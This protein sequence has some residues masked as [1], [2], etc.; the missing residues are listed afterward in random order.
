MVMG[1][2]DE[3]DD[4]SDAGQM[5]NVVRNNLVQG[6]RVCCGVA[7]ETLVV[8][9]MVSSKLHFRVEREVIAVLLQRFHVVTE[10]VVCT[11]GLREH[12]CEKTVAHA[13]TEKPFDFSLFR[14]GAI[15]PKAL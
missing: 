15:L 6:V 13:D 14:G 5:S 4:I 9:D 3:G 11:T 7:D 8:A 1:M 2:A 12:V 10:C